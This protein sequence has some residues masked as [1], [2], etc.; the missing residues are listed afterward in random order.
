MLWWQSHS[1]SHWLGGLDTSIATHRLHLHAISTVTTPRRPQQRH[2]EENWRLPY[3]P[4]SPAWLALSLPCAIS[5]SAVSS[6]HHRSASTTCRQR[7]C[8]GKIVMHESYFSDVDIDW[9]YVLQL[10]SD[11]SV[12]GADSVYTT[13]KWITIHSINAIALVTQRG[14]F[15]SRVSTVSY[16]E[17]DTATA[18]QFSVRLFVCSFVLLSDTCVVLNDWTDYQACGSLWTL[19]LPN[20]TGY[21]C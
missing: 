2:A 6:L 16:A 15:L 13:K 14:T 8:G 7:R 12:S 10:R 18:F 4:S 1:A 9:T 21:R 3:R 5:C 11:R 19:V 20:Q 17:H